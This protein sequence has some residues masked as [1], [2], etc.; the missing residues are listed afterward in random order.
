LRGPPGSYRTAIQRACDKHG[1]PEWFPDQIRHHTRA[2]DI[3]AQFGIKT[4]RTVLGHTER[5]TTVIYADPD[6]AQV[7]KILQKWG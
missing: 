7:A 5:A 2:T 4:S 1:I 3:R 6:F